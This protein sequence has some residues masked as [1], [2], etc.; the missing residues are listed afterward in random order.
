MKKDIRIIILV[1]VLIGAGVWYFVLSL[2]E[3]TETEQACI[4]S[5][6]KIKKSLCCKASRDFPNLCLIG[7]CACAPEYSHKVKTC[8]CG[9]GKC[10]DG[11]RCA[12]IEDYREP[13]EEAVV[14]PSSEEEKEEVEEEVEE[15]AAPLI[16]SSF[17][18]PHLISWIQEDSVLSL[19]KATLGTI[20]APAGLR[21]LYE[22]GNYKEGEKLYTFT[23][24]LKIQSGNSGKCVRMNIRREGDEAELIAPNTQQ[25]MFPGTGGC[26]TIPNTTYRDQKVIFVVPKIEKESSF[27]INNLYF[28]LSAEG[29]SLKLTREDWETYYGGSYGFNIKYPEKWYKEV[30]EKY[31]EDV[32]I[33]DPMK[34]G[35]QSGC[36]CYDD[37]E[38]CYAGV[39][40]VAVYIKGLADL[41]TLVKPLLSEGF[42]QTPLII[43]GREA[44]K[45]F[46]EDV[47]NEVYVFVSRPDYTL[48]IRY[49]DIYDLIY[50][51]TFDRMLNSMK[52]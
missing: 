9:E 20:S 17:S 25:F 7:P 30:C 49:K 15:E 40:S 46:K 51:K 34:V 16:E 50:L 39:V 35:A 52:L 23:L 26:S 13:E 6:G 41:D 19:T 48:K 44:R 33:F 22:I 3:L 12:S 27:V 36:S 5:G 45:L 24:Y 10:F 37:G 18:H 38:D 1:I 32:V 21:K 8:D 4:D 28:T 47:P 14:E 43:G 2:K 11:S 29:D 42:K 31:G